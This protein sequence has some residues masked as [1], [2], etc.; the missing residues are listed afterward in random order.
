MNHCS[1]FSHD[2]VDN[3]IVFKPET[4]GG[5]SS[6]I[7]DINKRNLCVFMAVVPANRVTVI[8]LQIGR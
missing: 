6:T 1:Y 2:L 7:S 3:K 8:C 5:T 4:V